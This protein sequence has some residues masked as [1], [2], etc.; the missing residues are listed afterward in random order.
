MRALYQVKYFGLTSGDQKAVDCQLDNDNTPNRNEMDLIWKMDGQLVHPLNDSIQFVADQSKYVAVTCEYNCS[1]RSS[2]ISAEHC[3]DIDTTQVFSQTF[4]IC[5]LDETQQYFVLGSAFIIGIWIVSFAFYLRT[6]NMKWVDNEENPTV[7][8]KAYD[9][10]ITKFRCFKM[11][12]ITIFA[13]LR[14]PIWTSAHFV[15]DV[16]TDWLLLFNHAYTGHYLW[17]ITT[18]CFIQASTFTN[19]YIGMRVM[20]K[21]SLVYPRLFNSV[22]KKMIYTF[23]FFINMGPVLFH[24]DE[25]L[26]KFQ[27]FGDKFS[28]VHVHITFSN[29][30][31][32]QCKPFSILYIQFNKGIFLLY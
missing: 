17:V 10:M 28:Q 11:H 30:L 5:A 15:F 12:M 21:Y 27:Q 6:K 4:L 2:N 16:V 22:K 8:P 18:F 9:K 25:A 29:F 3:Q 13:V 32:C 24:V 20:L 19:L 26:D 14:G 7:K 23:M 1:S 31:G